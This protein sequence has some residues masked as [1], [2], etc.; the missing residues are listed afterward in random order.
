MS[1]ISGAPGISAQH[2]DLLL[3][4]EYR[5]RQP[6]TV[7]FQPR[8]SAHYRGFGILEDNSALRPATRVGILALRTGNQ[9]DNSAMMSG[10]QVGNYSIDV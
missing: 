7:S 10:T 9:V 3:R 5:C 4:Y 2:H 1:F 6:S 8:S